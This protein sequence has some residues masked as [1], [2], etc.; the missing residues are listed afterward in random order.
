MD[1][2]IKLKLLL[3]IIERAL[4]PKIQSLLTEKV[5]FKQNTK[6]DFVPEELI[7]LHLYAF[8]ES[9]YSIYD[10]LYA[11]SH[12]KRTVED[13]IDLFFEKRT[14]L[15]A[16]IGELL[17]EVKGPKE[18][19]F[20]KEYRPNFK[21][22]SLFIREHLLL[23]ESMLYYSGR[24]HSKDVEWI[25]SESLMFKRYY[26]KG[27][28]GEAHKSFKKDVTTAIKGHDYSLAGFLTSYDGGWVKYSVIAEL[29]AKYIKTL[30]LKDEKK[31]HL[32]SKIGLYTYIL[33]GFY[34][35]TKKHQLHS[36]ITK[37]GL[38]TLPEHLY[39][40][41]ES[42]SLG[43]SKDRKDF[44]RQVDAGKI[45]LDE[46]LTKLDPRTINIIKMA[47]KSKGKYIQRRYNK[48]S[49][50]FKEK[51]YR[52]SLEE[53][54]ESIIPKYSKEKSTILNDCHQVRIFMNQDYSTR[55][56]TPTSLDPKEVRLLMQY[57]DA[58]GL[59]IN[60][61]KKTDIATQKAVYKRLKLLVKKIKK[62]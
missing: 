26:G 48:E 39:K 57:A 24:P 61:D 28:L 59:F 21:I 11:N 10:S 22:L 9:L 17:K 20:I 19:A 8:T 46:V 62:V 25:K 56:P 29:D 52:K 18:S 34:G 14:S 37:K 32:A 31:R 23:L 16:H 40:E 1:T 13:F 15:P 2:K 44:F 38:L 49:G 7:K 60:T 36:I 5:Y 47:G 41:L 58:E 55:I 33:T 3:S 50:D 54:L 6:I 42:R 35:V 30:K 27:F 12:G 51:L 45:I 53:N 4:K 43:L